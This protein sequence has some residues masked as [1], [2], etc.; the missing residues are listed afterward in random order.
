MGEKVQWT[1]IGARPSGEELRWNNVHL[2]FDHMVHFLHRSPGEAADRFRELGYHAVAGGR[3]EKWGTWNSLS[4]FGLSYVEFLAVERADVAE[5]SD[6]PLIRQL[7]N[8]RSAG[9]GFGQIAL[10]T[11]EMDRWDEELRKRGLQVRG[12][13]AGSRTREDGTVIRWRMLFLEDPSSRL[14]PPFLIEWHEED[15]GRERDLANRGILAPHPNGAQTI[16]S[17]GYAVADLDEAA[18]R[19]S[20]WFGWESSDIFSDEQLGARCRTFPLPGGDIVLCQ[21]TGA[22]WTQEAL[23]SRGERPFFVRLAG[24]DGSG[25]DTV[26]GGRY[27]RTGR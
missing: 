18:E 24:T 5:Q 2:T 10:R 26:F 9:E 21:P 14:I 27:V 8:E 12:P 11:R 23:T 7:V 4:Y 17:I 13:V 3:H 1:K 25:L 19:W 15:A 16:Q 20:R 6:N 22:G